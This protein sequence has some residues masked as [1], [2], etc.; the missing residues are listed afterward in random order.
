MKPRTLLE[1]SLTRIWRDFNDN[2]FCIITA[3]RDQADA[4]YKSNFQLIKDNI[5]R[6]GLGYIRID[7][8]GKDERDGEIKAVV[9][10]S[11]F[12]KNV[13]SSGESLMSFE[14]FERV[15]VEIA[16]KFNQW[17]LVLSHPDKGTRLIALKDE[18]GNRIPPTVQM[19]FKTFNPIKTAQFFSRLKEK[20]FTFEMFKYPNKPGNWM[21]GMAMEAQGAQ[22]I[23][24]YKNKDKWIEEIS[25]LISK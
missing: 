6:A 2:E 23:E 22:N 17:G 16:E 13:K 3:W 24:K 15:V 1:A 25:K 18:N 12:V 19:E 11:L 5:R 20:P 14:E 9:E 21:H 7:G 4:E 10:P 8:L